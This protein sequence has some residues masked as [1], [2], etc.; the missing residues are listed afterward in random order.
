MT[1]KQKQ[2]ETIESL[3]AAGKKMT[4]REFIRNAA[5]LGIGMTAASG[6]WSKIGL[7]V[8]SKP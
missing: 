8:T 7:E 1:T 2:F 3:M 6:M 4:R 5:I